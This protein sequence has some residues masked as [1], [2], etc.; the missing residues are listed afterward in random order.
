MEIIWLALTAVLLIIEI[1]TLGLTTIWFAAGA[2]FA[3]FAALLGMNQGIQIGV[4]VVVSVV[5]L[6]FTRPLAVKYLNTK[7]IKTNTEALVGKTARVIVDINN[8]KSQ[9]QV[10]I[11]GL[12]WTARSSDDTVV[13][14]I[15]DAVTIVGIEGVKLIVEGQKKG[16]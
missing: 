15:G 2:L 9:G 6:F 4:F 11:N 7:T 5:L 10:V 12:E 1:V 14:K 16:D 13:F 8:L 3:F